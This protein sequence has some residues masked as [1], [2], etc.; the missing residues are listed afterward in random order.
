MN[1]LTR[2]LAPLSVVLALTVVGGVTHA[3]PQSQRGVDSSRLQYER[4]RADCMQGR[5]TS[6]PRAVC[7][8][9]ASAAYA[10]ARRRSLAAP[11]GDAAMYSAN[12]AKRCDV[13]KGEARDICLRRVGGE[14][15][16]SGSVAAGGTLEALTV[17]SPPAAGPAQAPSAPPVPPKR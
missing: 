15:M 1:A 2:T 14:G 7:L 10:E 9:E 11:G 13:Q 5:S 4:D 12:A 17:K 16:V 6:Q 3:A 8:K